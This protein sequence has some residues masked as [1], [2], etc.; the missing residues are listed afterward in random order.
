[1]AIQAKM[2]VDERHERGGAT[3]P[4]EHFQEV[5]GY[6]CDCDWIPATQLEVNLSVVTTGD[7]TENASYAAATPSGDLN[8]IVDNPAAQDYFEIGK[9]YYVEI[10]KARK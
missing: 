6:D 5:H 3:R 9:E 1:M 8:L 7:G 10:R 2:K 4:P